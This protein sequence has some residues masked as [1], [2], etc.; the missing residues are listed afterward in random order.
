MRFKAS[1]FGQDRLQIEPDFDDGRVTRHEFD[2]RTPDGGHMH[3]NYEVERADEPVLELD[4]HECIIKAGTPLSPPQNKHV[5]PLSG[6]R[7]CGG[8]GVQK[9][10][11]QEEVHDG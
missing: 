2:F 8:E 5:T 9:E 6:T 3:L 7:D 11:V 10:G 4:N 1:Y